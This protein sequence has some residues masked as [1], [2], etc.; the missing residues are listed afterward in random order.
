MLGNDE[1]CLKCLALSTHTFMQSALFVLNHD[2]L[3]TV[4][5]VVV[6]LPSDW[7]LHRI[8]GRK[9]CLATIPLNMTF[10]S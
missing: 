5:F 8:V 10:S 3:L 1:L 7:P 9:V 2:V 4:V 6:I